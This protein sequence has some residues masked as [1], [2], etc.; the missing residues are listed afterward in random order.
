MPAI[1][2][3]ECR[4]STN[5]SLYY[6]SLNFEFWL[7]T[8][9]TIFLLFVFSPWSITCFFFYLAFILVCFGCFVYSFICVLITTWSIFQLSGDLNITNGSAANFYVC[10]ALTVV[11]SESYFMC[12]IKCNTGPPLNTY[13][14]VST[15]RNI[16]FTF[17]LLFP[18][19][20]QCGHLHTLVDC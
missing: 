7:R 12:H 1:I 15:R 2:H 5:E 10:L 8:W 9:Q 17:W 16:C 14:A 6:F 13:L 3:L 20:D 19:I 11:S 18:W 4:Y